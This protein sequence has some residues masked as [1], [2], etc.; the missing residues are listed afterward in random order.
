MKLEISTPGPREYY[1]EM[2]YVLSYY[3][4]IKKNPR[5]KVHSLTKYLSVFIVLL[6]IYIAI[7]FIANKTFHDLLFIYLAGI[8]SIL[9]AYYIFVLLNANK[10]IKE[11][12]NNTGTKIIEINDEGV[13][14]KDDKRDFLINWSSIHSIVIN[15]YSICFI[16]ED[17]SNIVVSISSEYANE[18]LKGI[19]EV[20]KEDL[21]YDN[22]K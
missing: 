2:L 3:K 12:I 20:N 17:M 6:I 1:D 10:R 4:K 18:V 11:Y 15:N 8:S 22:R 9:L 21:A 14:F 7:M 16:P 13:R 5:V 19:K